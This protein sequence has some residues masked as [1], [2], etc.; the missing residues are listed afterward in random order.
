MPTTATAETPI[1]DRAVTPPS[2]SPVA[3]VMPSN[4]DDIWIIKVPDQLEGPREACPA[5][6]HPGA[7]VGLFDI[8]TY[9]ETYQGKDIKRHKLFLVYE[10]SKKQ[11]DGSPFVMGQEMT[12]SMARNANFYQLVCSITG[13]SYEVGTQLDPRKLLGLP[14]LIQ[15]SNTRKQT[16]KGERTYANI[17]SVAQYPEGLPTYQLVRTPVVWSI[18]GGQPLPGVDWLPRIYGE[19]LSDVLSRSNEARQR[20]AASAAAAY[21]PS[22]EDDCPF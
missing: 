8:G 21:G 17:E 4:D 5:G 1:V 15:V 11:S 13:R 3:E 7:I 12:W 19:T 9:E 20:R 10:L 6:N 16:E 14:V 2:P 22:L 18:R